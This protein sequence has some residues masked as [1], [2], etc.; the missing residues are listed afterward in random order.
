MLALQA[1][2][3][4]LAPLPLSP[5]IRPYA[6]GEDVE[7]GREFCRGLVAVAVLVESDECILHQ[8]FTI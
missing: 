2:A 4:L 6:V 7:K 1:A 3:E 5:E 8:I